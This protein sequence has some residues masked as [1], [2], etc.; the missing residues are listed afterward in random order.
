M[1]EQDAI[2][3]PA[4]DERELHDASADYRLALEQLRDA[5]SKLKALGAAKQVLTDFAA[6]EA[7][8]N[9]ELKVAREAVLLLGR[10]GAQR[11]IAARALGN[12]ER[13]A[14]V[15][16]ASIGIALSVEV[17]WKSDAQGPAKTCDVCGTPFGSSAKVKLCPSCGAQ[18]G[19]HS[20]DRLSIALSNRSGAAEDLAGLAVGLAASDWLRGRRAS[21]WG[22][23]YLDE[24]FG[25]L[26]TYHKRVL[27]AHVAGLLRAGSSQA[28]VVA[29]DRGLLDAF[30][31]RIIVTGTT[32]GSAVRAEG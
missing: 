19:Q 29:H 30:P 20:V 2:Q 13:G 10:Q 32:S 18:R 24:P 23:V 16:L 28:L 15:M 8:L 21:A 9:A 14:N 12:I 27:G 25:A 1:Q 31:S 4:F 11:I 26:D 17:R 6:V 5:E 22:A 3:V 7:K